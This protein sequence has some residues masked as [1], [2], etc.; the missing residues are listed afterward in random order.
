MVMC[1]KCGQPS[2]EIVIPARPHRHPE[3]QV[4]FAGMECSACAYVFA[5]DAQRQENETRYNA[6][7]FELRTEGCPLDCAR[8]SA[9]CTQD[10]ICLPQPRFQWT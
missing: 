1:I 6:A 4:E 8:R 5:T 7:C 2:V 3:L 9:Q 10:P